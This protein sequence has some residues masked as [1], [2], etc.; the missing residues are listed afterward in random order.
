MLKVI[1]LF[2]MAKENH[3]KGERKSVVTKRKMEMVAVWCRSGKH[4]Q[5]MP[6]ICVFYETTRPVILTLGISIG[7]RQLK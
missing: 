4:D 5:S 2:N 1:L 3:K 7:S 6:L